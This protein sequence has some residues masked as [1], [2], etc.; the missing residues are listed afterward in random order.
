MKFDIL[1][2][3]IQATGVSE[4]S[5][6]RYAGT[7]QSSIRHTLDKGGDPRWTTGQAII[8]LHVQLVQEKAA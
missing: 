8:N 2:R 1:I 3:E 6:A 7:S 4:R 5:I